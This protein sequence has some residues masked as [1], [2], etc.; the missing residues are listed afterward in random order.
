MKIIITKEKHNDAVRIGDLRKKVS[1][2]RGG[3]GGDGG[4]SQQQLTSIALQKPV[5]I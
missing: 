2:K 3:G 1:K 5:E 4:A